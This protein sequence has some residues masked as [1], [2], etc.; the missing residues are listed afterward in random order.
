MTRQSRLSTRLAIA[1]VSAV[2]AIAC[3]S[4]SF[5]ISIELKDAAPDRIERQRA[6]AEG[7]LPLPE[8]PDIS[9]TKERVTEQGFKTGAPIF[10]R[11][12][13]EQSELEIW[14]EK[15][16]TYEL[17]AK[18]PICHWSGSLGPKLR[19]G[20]KQ[21]P[22]GF[23]TVAN[24]Q[25][26]TSGKWPLSLNLGYP[27][28]FDKSQARNGAHILVHG[29]CS[30]VGCYAMTNPVIN[31]IYRLS[32]ASLSGGQQHIPVHV[33]PFRM[34]EANLDKY[35]THEWRDFWLNLKDGYDAFERTK[36]PPKVS[37]CDDKYLFQDQS[38]VEAGLPGPLAVCGQTAAMIEELEKFDKLVTPGM[39]Q[40]L[41]AG[42]QSGLG[43][44]AS[45]AAPNL[46]AIASRAAVEPVTQSNFNTP[47]IRT[48]GLGA[49]LRSRSYSC[50][51]GLASCRKFIALQNRI[52]GKRYGVASQGGK[53]RQRTAA[54]SQ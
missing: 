49:A 21:A 18:Y 29:G 38:P 16:E 4:S 36:R 10:I 41:L 11:I 12:F 8:T 23:Y 20:D 1:A 26:H 19:Q 34:T 39:L 52:A 40:T 42:A 22:E 54:R 33:F 43:F 53:K 30:S 37:V 13:K 48:A 27:N 15:G 28:A 44:S 25:L 35:K 47:R 14:M 7:R 32:D 46:M 31:E 50:S 9:R 45:L 5:A 2:S 3:A 6:A 24:S 51:T 17:F